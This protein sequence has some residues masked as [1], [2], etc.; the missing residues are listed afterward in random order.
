VI[1]ISL[2]HLMFSTTLT[3][4][5]WDVHGPPGGNS[6]AG[7]GGGPNPIALT[8]DRPARKGGIGRRPVVA[9]LDT[10][11]GPHPWFDLADR[12]H[13]VLYNDFLT[14]LPDLQTT[15][16]N[17]AVAHGTPVL[18][19]YWDTPSTD[20][21]LVGNLD[22]AIGHGTFVAGIIRQKAPDARVLAIRV[23]HSDGIAY[24]GDVVCAMQSVVDRVTAA[25]ISGDLANMVDVV[26]LSLGY[27]DE[28]QVPSQMATALR[29]AI[30]QLTGLGVL[31]VASAG[32]DSTSR[33]CYPAAMAAE[34]RPDPGGGPQ[35]IS[36]GAK[37]PNGT[38]AL[39]SNEGPW[40][41]HLEDGADVVSTFP[42]DIRGA[43]QPL[44]SIG[45]RESL[46]PD[47]FS[48]GFA[49][50]SGTSFSAPLAAARIAAKMVELAAATDG[51]AIPL[52]LVDQAST[53]KRAGETIGGLGWQQ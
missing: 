21:P 39:F 49:V 24:E 36:V 26:S 2:E 4:E 9:V 48:G 27:Y 16:E 41:R 28:D 50:W 6:C 10:G 37:N 52:D 15:I 1:G 35:V 42:T 14:V 51:S 45:T 33:P 3:T 12:S 29:T 8:M 20:N 19:G 13:P 53:I 30:D 31:V 43:R 25:Q 44:M 17:G 34:P 40:V 38:T 22:P 7:W 11:I 5:P 46:A 32:N 23:A 47:D 18:S